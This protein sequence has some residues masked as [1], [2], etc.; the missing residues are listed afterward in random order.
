MEGTVSLAVYFVA[1]MNA[2]QILTTMQTLVRVKEMQAKAK[3]S[4]DTIRTL[5]QQVDT[6]TKDNQRQRQTLDTIFKKMQCPSCFRYLESKGEG[7]T[8]EEYTCDKVV[9]TRCC[10]IGQ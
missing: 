7:D 2:K 8:I 5:I 10:G 3:E 6:L 4:E 9:L 1:T